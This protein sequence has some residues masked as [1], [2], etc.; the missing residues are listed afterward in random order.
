MLIV[1]LD[2]HRPLVLLPG[3][4]QRTL[5][6]WFRKYPEIQVVSRDRSGVYATAA[7]EGAPQARQVA[8]R[9]HLLKSIGD[10]PERMM[11]RHMP[12]IRLVVR[13]LS[14][15]KSPEPEISVPVHRSVV[16]NALNSK[17]AKNGISIGQRLW[18]CITRDVVSGKYPVLQAC[19]E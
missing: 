13:E 2:T 9:W 6:T 16:R 11:Y 15:N 14:L 4:D 18:P 5:A 10:E 8:D 19:R 17:P 1:N 7:R 12:L 3:R